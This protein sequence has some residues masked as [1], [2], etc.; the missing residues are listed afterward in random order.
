M[1]HIH[2]RT[3]LTLMMNLAFFVHMSSTK[4]VELLMYRMSRDL[5]YMR[6]MD[7]GIV[8]VTRTIQKQRNILI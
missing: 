2:L 3:S 8:P 5:V 4:Y 7:C 1:E 6:N